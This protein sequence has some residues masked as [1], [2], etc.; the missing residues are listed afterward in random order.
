[1][2]LNTPPTA[3]TRRRRR[4]KR[5]FTLLEVMVSAAFFLVGIA[6]I[7]S[8]I[9]TVFSLSTRNARLTTAFR[10]AEWQMESLLL[11]PNSD[12][13]MVVGA[14]YGPVHYD[15]DGNAS[16][17]AV[18]N[19]YRATWAVATG[20]TASLRRVT[21]TVAWGDGSSLRR[22]SMSTLRD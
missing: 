2:S 13:E 4:T 19:G 15:S 21:V 16:A 14:T 7:T 12:A 17:S 18:T 9:S 3:H 20:P 11:R 1:M 5:G 22:W 8:T 6:G 10:V